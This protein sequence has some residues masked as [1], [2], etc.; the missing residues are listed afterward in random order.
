M[1]QS[2]PT[3]NIAEYH[4]TLRHEAGH[5]LMATLLGFKALGIRVE[6]SER[7]EC[8]VSLEIPT[9]DMDTLRL[10]LENRCKQLYAGFVAERVRDGA[11]HAEM[12]ADEIWHT[13]SA[14]FRDC[15]KFT[16]LIYFLANISG[17]EPTPELREKI[18]GRL[19]LET[20]SL[21]VK[22]SATLD[23][24][25]EFLEKFGT[26]FTCPSGLINEAP[27]VKSALASG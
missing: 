10:F 23:A 22:H 9:P 13:S 4:R 8:T 20:T 12:H 1:N 24:I 19:K 16:E 21:L 18:G 11:V 27:K 6:G 25:V 2:G 5:W 15:A 7:G 3:V 26:D 17:E 14:Y